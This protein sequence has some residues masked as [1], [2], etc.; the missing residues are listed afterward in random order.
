LAITKQRKKELVDQYE[1]W[2]KRS[3]AIILTE[4]HG[5]SMKE[6]DDL[7]AKV[8]EA[9]GEFH[10]VKNTLGKVA[11]QAVGLS[12]PEDF[13]DGSTAI[14]FAFQHPPEMAKLV[15]DYAKSSEFVKIKGGYL[16]KLPVSAI[17]IKA[18]A[19]LPPL[20]VMRAQLL[21]TILAPASQLVRTI[22][23]PVRQV[24]YLLKSYADKDSTPEMA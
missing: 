16:N 20:P 2:L 23:E 13:L 8:R 21:G 5:L 12:L 11:F 22:A 18:L 19:E 17:D 3:E 1:N 6:I 4:Y 9:G 7:R 10:I 14:T 24:A 15:S